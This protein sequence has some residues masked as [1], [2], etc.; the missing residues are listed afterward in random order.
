MTREYFWLKVVKACSCGGRGQCGS[1][2]VSSP[3]INNDYSATLTV[4]GNFQ[5][6]DPA[7]PRGPKRQATR[8]SWVKFCSSLYSLILCHHYRSHR[9]SS[10]KSSSHSRQNS[11]IDEQD[12]I[13]SSGF[14][15][16]SEISRQQDLSR[17]NTHLAPL[18]L[19]HR[20]QLS[21]KSV[22][23]DPRIWS[24]RQL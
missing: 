21:S 1:Y 14:E 3:L 18:L 17:V 23:E 9:A 2:F 19:G 15:V 13:I 4:K 11:G 24:R 8:I 16:D 10:S 7:S 12:H 22:S 5:G 6:V 20:R